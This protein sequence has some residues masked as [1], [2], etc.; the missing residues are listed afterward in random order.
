MKVESMLPYFS[1][2]PHD[3]A[4]KK[5]P[6][7]PGEAAVAYLVLRQPLN[8]SVWLYFFKTMNGGCL[9]KS[10]KPGFLRHTLFELFIKSSIKTLADVSDVIVEQNTKSVE[11]V[12]F[13]AVLLCSLVPYNHG[14]GRNA[15][16]DECCQQN[17][18]AG[19]LVHRLP[20]VSFFSSF[21][22]CGC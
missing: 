10:F 18:R 9:K 13:P 22:Q 12:I 3:N 6:V 21:F 5:G 8:L 15:E 11:S 7:V 2:W 19:L 4:P 20:P 16:W 14:V 17:A 1:I